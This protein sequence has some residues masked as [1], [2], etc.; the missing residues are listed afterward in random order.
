MYPSRVQILYLNS[1]S[2]TLSHKLKIDSST[3][4]SHHISH[5]FNWVSFT[6]IS[7]SS[8]YQF[9]CFT[10]TLFPLWLP[11]IWPKHILDH[12]DLKA[13]AAT[14]F[15]I[16]ILADNKGGA[17]RSNGDWFQGFT[18]GRDWQAQVLSINIQRIKQKIYIKSKISNTQNL[19]FQNCNPE[20]SLL[21]IHT[22]QINKRN[23]QN[24]KQNQ[25]FVFLSFLNIINSQ[26]MKETGTGYRWSSPPML[27]YYGNN[28]ILTQQSR[29]IIFN[30]KIGFRTK[31]KEL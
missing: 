22:T 14:N 6:F 25:L 23:K 15:M 16:A 13:L 21:T 5:S 27:K 26:I 9:S 12:C 17:I 4:I 3:K 1:L 2:P 7:S 24:W 11:K 18:F 10:Y 19:K 20:G 31:Q 30:K 28:I 8:F 29:I